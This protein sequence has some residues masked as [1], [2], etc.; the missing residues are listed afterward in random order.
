MLTRTV[1]QKAA[2]LWVICL[3]LF[4]LQPLRPEGTRGRGVLLHQ[5]EH[6]VIFA[7]TGVLLVTLGRS[8]SE[9]WLA[10]LCV[11]ALAGAIEAAQLAIYRMELGFEWWDVRDDS[12]GAL[13]G[14][15]A[16]RLIPVRSLLLKDPRE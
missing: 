9:E 12:I 3:V 2:L 8:K 4:S 11:V 6:V 14:L 15:I 1:L 10:L 5:I 16:V 13:F 7:A